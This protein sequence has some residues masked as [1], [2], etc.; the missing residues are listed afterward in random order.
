M[1]CGVAD[2]I[3]F[4]RMEPQGGGPSLSDFVRPC[5]KPSV[6]TDV[7]Q[8]TG[9]GQVNKP[10]FLGQFQSGD[11]PRVEVSSGHSPHPCRRATPLNETALRVLTPTNNSERR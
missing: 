9:T 8:S 11:L 5:Y 10:E 4:R 1:S 6:G 2:P 3:R 7:R